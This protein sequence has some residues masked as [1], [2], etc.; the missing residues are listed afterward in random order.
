[1]SR[2]VDATILVRICNTN[3]L[4]YLPRSTG[5]CVDKSLTKINMFLNRKFLFLDLKCISK[6]TFTQAHKFQYLFADCKTL[7]CFQILSNSPFVLSSICV[8]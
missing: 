3:F 7:K 4:T 6:E 2:C 5:F 8:H 1:M